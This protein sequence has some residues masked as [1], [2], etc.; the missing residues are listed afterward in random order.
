M[1]FPTAGRAG[2]F[3]RRWFDL[4]RLPTSGCRACASWRGF[5]SAWTRLVNLLNGAVL[6]ATG[7]VCVPEV[8]A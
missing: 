1:A 2:E 7:G 4:P 3:R 5:V 8:G 6:A